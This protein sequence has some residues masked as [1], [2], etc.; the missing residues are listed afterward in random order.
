MTI[1]VSNRLGGEKRGSSFVTQ[2]FLGEY[3]TKKAAF[4]FDFE[5]PTHCLLE[6]RVADVYNRTTNCTVFPISIN[7]SITTVFHL[8]ILLTSDRIDIRCKLLANF[9]TKV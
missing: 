7:Q 2:L 1:T 6:N 9:M 8:A 4:Q 3:A 5:R